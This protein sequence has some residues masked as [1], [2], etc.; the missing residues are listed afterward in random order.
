[1]SAPSASLGGRANDLREARLRIALRCPEIRVGDVWKHVHGVKN[2]RVV[3][4][5][6]IEDDGIGAFP[7]PMVGFQVGDGQP[8][9]WGAPALIGE[10][11]AKRGR[12]QC[13]S[14]PVP[15]RPMTAGER[16]KLMEMAKAATGRLKKTASVARAPAA[17]VPVVKGKPKPAA[18]KR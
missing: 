3:S 12:G 1:M 10:Q 6:P 9:E 18:R 16:R 11:L 8:F 15:E 7:W 5:K 13:W 14:P 17:R 2:A 4:C